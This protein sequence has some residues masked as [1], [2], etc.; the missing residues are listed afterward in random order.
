MTY[1]CHHPFS[2]RRGAAMALALILVFLAGVTALLMTRTLVASHRA[3]VLREQREQARLLADAA[4]DHAVIRLRADGGYQGESW[5]IP[6][7]RLDGRH[8][9]RTEIL[10]RALSD[11]EFPE[12]RTVQVKV[13]YPSNDETPNRALIRR[14]IVVE[15]LAQGESP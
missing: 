12:R 6:A 11:E 5:E 10:V 9:S 3:A 14:E 15:S 8:A 7:E 2:A 13:V 4:V 1:Q